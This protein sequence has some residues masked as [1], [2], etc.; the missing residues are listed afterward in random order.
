MEK[1]LTALPTV[2]EESVVNLLKRRFLD[3]QIF[4]KLGEEVLI[5][6]N[7]FRDD[8]KVDEETKDAGE[9]RIETLASTAFHDAVRF[10]KAFSCVMTGE[11]GSGKTE[12][13]KVYLKELA[14]GHRC[15]N[16]QLQLQLVD[17]CTLL[18]SFG[19][20]A[21]EHN[22]NSSR[23]ARWF[24]LH[25][26]TAIGKV[27]S[28]RVHQYLLEKGR[29]VNGSSK[30]SNFHVLYD[31]CQS[32]DDRAKGDIEKREDHFKY[33]CGRAQGV[34]GRADRW[35]RMTRQLG[36][37]GVSPMDQ[38][39]LE[40]ALWCILYLGNL[41]FK[42]IDAG[43][44]AE[45]CALVPESREALEHVTDL[46]GMDGDTAGVEALF[47]TRRLR[48][49]RE[50]VTQTRTA[51]QA[52]EARDALAKDLY[53]RIFRYIISAINASIDQKVQGVRD[54]YR[55][56]TVSI[57]DIFGFERF[58]NNSFEQLC[59]NY[60]NEKLVQQF[61]EVLVRAE[62]AACRAEGVPDGDIG[63]EDA[64]EAEQAAKAN[65]IEGINN[66]FKIIQDE[67]RLPRATDYTLNKKLLQLNLG[68]PV[69]LTR[70]G[71]PVHFTVNH[72]A[73]LV[74]YNAQGFL[75]KNRD[76]APRG[77]E[78]VILEKSNNDFLRGLF[79][80][81]SADEEDDEETGKPKPRAQA[82]QKTL[83]VQ[84]RDEFSSLATE[85]AK[86]S[87]QFVMCIKPNREASPGYFLDKLV[88]DQLEANGT[89]TI[90]RVRQS[91][92]VEHVPKP[93][94]LDRYGFLAEQ[95]KEP[96]TAEDL[97]HIMTETSRLLDADDLFVGKTKILLRLRGRDKLDV[98]CEK[99]D[100]AAIKVEAFARTVILRCA[101][102]RKRCAAIKVQA[103]IRGVHT[104]EEV[105]RLRIRMLRASLIVQSFI[106]MVQARKTVEFLRT[107]RRRAVEDSAA[108]CIQAFVR[109]ILA[110]AALEKLKT[111]RF[112]KA[113]LAKQ[114]VAIV[115][116]QSYARMFIAA[117]RYRRT[118]AL[119]RWRRKKVLAA[120]AV[121]A[122]VR[123]W[124]QRRR[125]V[126]ARLR[127]QREAA[128]AASLAA[129]NA[130]RSG[131]SLDKSKSESADVKLYDGEEDAV[132]QVAAPVNNRTGTQDVYG[133]ENK[134]KSLTST[135]SSINSED[136][137]VNAA[138]MNR[139][140]IPKSRRKPS[141]SVTKAAVVGTAVAAG[142]V[143]SA[144]AISAAVEPVPATDSL[145]NNSAATIVASEV[146]QKSD[147]TSI[148]SPDVTS[149][150]DASPIKAASTASPAAPPKLSIVAPPGA[151][152]SKPIDAP[153][154][155]RNSMAVPPELNSIQ[156]AIRVCAA[157]V[158]QRKWRAERKIRKQKE[159]KEQKVRQTKE[160]L[161][162]TR[163]R[164]RKMVLS[165]IVIQRVFR[166]FRVRKSLA[167]TRK[168]PTDL[169]VST[170]SS[171]RSALSSFA[172]HL[173]R[174]SNASPSASAHA[175]TMSAPTSAN[176]DGS[177]TSGD[178]MDEA[179]SDSGMKSTR[180]SMRPHRLSTHLRRFTSAFKSG[181]SFS[182]KYGRTE[183]EHYT[184]VA[185]RDP[186]YNFLVVRS[187]P[188]SSSPASPPP[189]THTD[190]EY[191][192]IMK[193]LKTASEKRN[194]TELTHALKTAYDRGYIS[195]TEIETA[196][197]V[198]AH[199]RKVHLKQ[200]ELEQRLMGVPT[201]T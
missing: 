100:N 192:H 81:E 29:V 136:D 154:S 127:L 47:A 126:R 107:E 138:L 143:G 101:F 201:N 54:P 153:S 198:L 102:L 181:K 120:I 59:I 51:V 33:L 46:L 164:L 83:G 23:F 145:A 185:T 125:L 183:E 38:T 8:I 79:A 24:E 114:D 37:M 197:A 11:S 111:E 155:K 174:G 74:V 78:E 173:R 139:A 148:A 119:A 172:N 22:H 116:V 110:K 52:H 1:D 147:I 14:G 35:H 82:K 66:A 152:T 149:V 166:G 131:S 128:A 123:G 184:D 108:V 187:P 160:E 188:S 86:S 135:S 34:K 62:V 104:R 158:I 25:V 97:V 18:E 95:E 98:Y 186:R 99:R 45:G 61:H 31:I 170:K 118:L 94:F 171:T 26:D 30:S 156:E 75:V 27:V 36:H 89:L 159:A 4:T 88:R 106:R 200:L 182:Q 122:L 20:C 57:L 28:G 69:K 199:I 72:Y 85:L 7:P 70:I 112:Q 134:P 133:A 92:F 141:K 121:Q 150:P 48:T 191:R 17:S 195:G 65:T 43:G 44:G 32:F 137:R 3:E 115:R 146:V 169:K 189:P 90:C 55:S 177:T 40:A 39:S 13:T 157:I 163:N 109:Q 5:K 6:V 80:S 168:L 58:E 140:T 2:T 190:P 9:P 15:A 179:A 10:K 130:Q 21:T 56:T 144:A 16:E 180:K 49:G 178:T 96:E 64:Y 63:L 76:E 67:T 162:A 161:Q 167:P 42:D 165:A 194:V 124:L 68:E 103:L 129:M 91:A 105:A 196:E 117:T 12:A 73:G 142:A 132:Q 53:S 175:A 87:Q 151:A 19:N 41:E 50:Y 93:V 77:V 176:T 60:G 71:N 193:M 113:L 84:F